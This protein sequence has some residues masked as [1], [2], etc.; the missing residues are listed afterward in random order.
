MGLYTG[1]INRNDLNG[2]DDVVTT[3]TED[4]DYP[5][6]YVNL[7]NKDR[8]HEYYQN[9]D[10]ILEKGVEGPTSEYAHI[11]DGK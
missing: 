3:H 7:T 1:S 6:P 10:A 2:Y 8:S 9:P 11:D 4:K 5:H